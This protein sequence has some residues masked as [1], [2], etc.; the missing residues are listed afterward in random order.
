MNV[1]M[2]NHFFQ[3]EEGENGGRGKKVPDMEGSHQP[4][5]RKLSTCQM[6][7]PKAQTTSALLSF[8]ATNTGRTW[9]RHML[10]PVFRGCGPVFC[11]T[12]H[13]PS[14]LPPI[15]PVFLRLKP[16]RIPTHGIRARNF[17]LDREAR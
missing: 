8:R 12:P 9:M 3:T 4:T 17:L 1:A 14:F 11:Q 7:L 5:L 15:S 2:S 6:A 10:G 13:L 16:T